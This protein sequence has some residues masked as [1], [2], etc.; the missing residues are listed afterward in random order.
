MLNNLLFFFGY[1]GGLFGVIAMF[2]N[3]ILSPLTLGRKFDKKFNT[4]NVTILD[5]WNGP[6]L[7]A[8]GYM[9]AIVMFDTKNH[10]P[11]P[12]FSSKLTEECKQYDFRAHASI[13]D[14]ILSFI[15]LISAGLMFF[16]MILWYIVQVIMYFS[17]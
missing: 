8:M 6:M 1:T 2:I 9:V 17:S 12:W 15:F 13:Y 11:I 3:F 10:R 7:R 14:L 4:S 5:A 16:F